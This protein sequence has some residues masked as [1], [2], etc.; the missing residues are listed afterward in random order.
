MN[1]GKGI[2]LNNKIHRNMEE[3]KVPAAVEHMKRK[4]YAGLIKKKE[5]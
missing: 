1:K 5:K 3:E 2:R 4:P